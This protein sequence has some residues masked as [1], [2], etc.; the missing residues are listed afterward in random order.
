[1]IIKLFQ[2]NKSAVIQVWLSFLLVDIENCQTL[3]YL[4]FLLLLQFSAGVATEFNNYYYGKTVSNHPVSHIIK[5]FYNLCTF[6]AIFPSISARI[7]LCSD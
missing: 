4:F 5:V 2:Y 3:N 6:V 1:M 7:K